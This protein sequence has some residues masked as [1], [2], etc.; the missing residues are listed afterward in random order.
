MEIKGPG[1]ISTP[2]VKR[3][4]GQG[5]ADKAAFKKA[6]STEETAP[7][8]HLSG[9]AP[10][11]AVDSLLSLQEL[12]TA[13]EGRSKGLAR[14]EDML[15]HLEQ[16]QQG[17]LLGHMPKHRLQDIARAISKEQGQSQDPKLDN[18]LRDIELR[19]KVEMAKLDMLG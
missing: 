16:I 11:A 4:K 8:S 9:T 2:G 12:P 3:K 5:S 13:T 15:Q 1:R 10:L 14:A 6:L 7:A 17:L 18:I 19:V